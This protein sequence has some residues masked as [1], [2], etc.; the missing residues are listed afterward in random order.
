MKLWKLLLLFAS[1]VLGGGVLLLL[2][3][4]ENIHIGNCRSETKS[5]FSLSPLRSPVL[6]AGVAG[7]FLIHLAA[8]YLPFGRS[9]L[10]TNPVSLEQWIV[11]LALALTR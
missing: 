10:G 8:M 4:F 2:V 9:I 7:A 6:L 5:A 3:L 1:L 11:F